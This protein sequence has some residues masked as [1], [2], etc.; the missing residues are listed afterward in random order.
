MEELKR[1]ICPSCYREIDPEV[2]WCGD[3][4]DHPYFDNHSGIPMGCHCGFAKN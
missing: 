1:E 4:I 3:P 2:C